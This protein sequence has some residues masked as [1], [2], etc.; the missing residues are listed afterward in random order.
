METVIKGTKTI[1]E[2]KEVKAK[3]E[4]LA[5]EAFER[6]KKAFEGWS[7]GDIKKAWFDDRGVLC[8]QYTSGNW[9]HYENDGTWW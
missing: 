7:E 8:I 9:W 6:H 5:I 3:L 1:E 4:K 2:Y